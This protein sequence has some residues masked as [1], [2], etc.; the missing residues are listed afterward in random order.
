MLGSVRSDEQAQILEEPL[1]SA[2]DWTIERRPSMRWTGPAA[3]ANAMRLRR[4]P[5]L[6][7]T[8]MVTH[9]LTFLCQ[10]ASKETV[11]SCCV[12]SAYRPFS[13]PPFLLIRA[14]LPIQPFRALPAHPA[15][16][17]AW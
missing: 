14:L 2:A 13:F 10:R 7:G 11:N 4:S 3:N 1:L 17:P 12:A 5:F 8:I 16:K 15:L 9:V 6:P